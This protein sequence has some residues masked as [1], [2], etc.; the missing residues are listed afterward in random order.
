MIRVL[1][2]QK[3]QRRE[4]AQNLFLSELLY[5]VAV[6]DLVNE[7]F[8]GLETWNKML[9]DNDR[10]VARNVAR[11]FFLALFID[12]AAEATDINIMSARHGIFYDRKECFY[13]R[14]DISFVDAGFFRNLINN[15]CFRHGAWVLLSEFR[16]GKINLRSQN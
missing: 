13:G 15:V 3:G 1:D 4:P 14:R 12:E 7:N 16:E 2:I 11:N 9:I 6:L 8:G 10:G 5:F